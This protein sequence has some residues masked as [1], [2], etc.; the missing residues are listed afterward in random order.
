LNI[1]KLKYTA[2]KPYFSL[3]L[4][5]YGT[6]VFFSQ[7]NNRERI[8]ALGNL[9]RNPKES[10]LY[11]QLNTIKNV[12]LIDSNV[13]QPLANGFE[14][15]TFMDASAGLLIQKDSKKTDSGETREFS[16]NNFKGL[17]YFLS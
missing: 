17:V 4:K 8:Q 14:F 9:L 5:M 10:M 16:I 6:E 3:S 13:R 2:E 11:G 7:I 1:I 15:N 12:L